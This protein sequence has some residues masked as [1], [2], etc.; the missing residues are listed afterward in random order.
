MAKLASE[1]LPKTDA[2]LGLADVPL[3]SIEGVKSGTAQAGTQHNG[4]LRG[5]DQNHDTGIFW[6]ECF[7]EK[8]N[9]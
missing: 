1:E 9:I 8:I 4:N 3:V 7:K 6:T 5:S 2:R